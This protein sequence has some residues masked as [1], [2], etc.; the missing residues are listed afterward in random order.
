MSNELSDPAKEV[1]SSF[2]NANANKNANKNASIIY[3]KEK[4][5]HDGYD[6]HGP[7]S[8]LWDLTFIIELNNDYLFY[9]YHWEDWFN[10]EDQENKYEIYQPSIKLSE[11]TEEN[12]NYFEKE[13]TD[14]K[15]RATFEKR[16]KRLQHQV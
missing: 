9:Y 5:S 2:K 6:S 14:N 1:L 12:I 11:T 4:L 15:F 13:T 3:V 10:C 8:D 7:E 16:L